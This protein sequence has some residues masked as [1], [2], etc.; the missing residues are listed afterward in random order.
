M[1]PRK[2]DILI[3]G[4]GVIGVS[5][6]YYAASMGAGVLLV[7]K[8][9]A[10]SG[11]SH[12]NAGLLASG[13]CTPL[14]GPGVLGEG[15][16]SLMDP[17][18]PL[19]IRPR[20]ET[21]LARWLWRFRRSC[22]DSHYSYAVGILKGLCAESL[23]LH[24]E[25]GLLGGGEY[26][27]AQEGIITMYLSERAFEDAR[28]HA[29]RMSGFGVEGAPLDGNR[30]RELEPMVGPRV[31]G[32]I[33]HAMDGH[34]DPG[35]FV[36]WLAAKAADKGAQILTDTEVYRFDA[37]RR[38]VNGVSTTRG[39]IRADQI[40]LAAGAFI[41]TLARG[42]GVRI[43][44]QAA[45]GYSCTFHRNGAGPRFPFLLGEARV[46]VTPYRGAVRF[47]GTLELAGMDMGINVRRLRA[48][49]ARADEYLPHFGEMEVKE[50]W[51]GLRACT[52]DGLPV[53]GRLHPLLNVMV[54]G[55]H[56]TKGM[57]L[58]PVT[59]KLAAR[60]LSGESA[61]EIERP[62]SPRRF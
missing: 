44:I 45:K 19:Y 25:L 54:A 49:R 34:I 10:G 3:V 38:K 35:A 23:E 61:G 1:A 43:P 59:G 14:P 41:P 31:V 6:A 36:R 37:G 62:L 12:G 7:E 4:G 28:R 56:G 20:I 40:V 29:A 32:G 57:L 50:I 21:E 8:A 33:C 48:L 46:A 13:H 18:G 15:L 58:G 51:R 17:E 39:E 60:V 5:V 16:S 24:R 53:L 26:E 22:S 42:L 9:A 47:A 30:I 11:C 52:P 2:V 27:Y 55:G